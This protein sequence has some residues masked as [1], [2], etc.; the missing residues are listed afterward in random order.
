MVTTKT[1]LVALALVGIVGTLPTAHA[2]AITVPIGHIPNTP[3]R[4]VFITSTFHTG[5]SADINVY[6]DFVTAAANLDIGMASLNTTWKVL[7]STVATNVLANTGLSASDTTTPFYN[8]R[9]LLIATGVTVGGSGLFGGAST[10]HLSTIFTETGA[11]SPINAALTGTLA[12]GTTSL[13]AL[14]NPVGIQRLKYGN[15][16]L[17]TGQWIA[18]DDVFVNYN[19]LFYG[20]S[21]VLG[22]VPEPAT[23]ALTGLGAVLAFAFSKLRKAQN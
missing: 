1:Y 12:D 14:G 8:T 10:A 6:N 2:A 15:P 7:G 3:Y 9:G 21:G 17:L 5:A 18:A 22:T 4:I 20:V 13:S 23:I 11:V 19:G 16:Q